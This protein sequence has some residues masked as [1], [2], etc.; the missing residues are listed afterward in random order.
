MIIE[1]ATEADLDAIVELERHSFPRPWPRSTFETELAAPQSR[2]EVG[3]LGGV[4]VGFVNYWLVADE[5][6]IHSI[7]THPDHRRAGLGTQLLDHMLAAGRAVGAT[8]ATLEVRAGNAPAIALYTRAGFTTVH[9]RPRYYQDNH[10]D[11]LIMTMPL[12]AS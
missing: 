3:R 4:I 1:R 11:A 12:L 8:L 10:E 2:L 7:T 6:H 5:L 9:T